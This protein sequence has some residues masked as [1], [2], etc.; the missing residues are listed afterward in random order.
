MDTGALG[1]IGVNVQHL[2]AVASAQG[3]DIATIHLQGMEEQIV[4]ATL[5]THINVI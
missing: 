3:Y 5:H 4:Q 1:E 2:A